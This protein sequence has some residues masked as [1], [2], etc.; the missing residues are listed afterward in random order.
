MLTWFK[1]AWDN[2]ANIALALLLLAV[3]VQTYR[4]ESSQ[5]DYTR[6]ET[7]HNQVKLDLKTA[8]EANQILATAVRQNNEAIIELSRQ[9]QSLDTALLFAQDQNRAVESQLATTLKRIQD[10][11]VSDNAEEAIQWSSEMNNELANA[12]NRAAR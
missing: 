1:F 4:L 9:R 2:R 3:G 7:Q 8:K 12:W 6:L 10:A 5:E 11:D